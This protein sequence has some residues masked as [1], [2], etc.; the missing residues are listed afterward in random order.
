MRN[1]ASFDPVKPINRVFGCVT[2]ASPAVLPG[3]VKKLTT[4]R[5][6]PASYKMSMKI[7]AIVGES[8]DGF[9]IAVLPVT[10]AAAVI[11]PMIAAAKFHGGIITPT[12]SGMYFK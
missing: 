1:P 12:P 10:I 7:A 11:P 6:T 9:T 8:L 2:S 3:P 5:G 4:S